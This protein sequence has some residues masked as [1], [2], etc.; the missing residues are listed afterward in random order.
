MAIFIV[1]ENSA[2]FYSPNLD[3]KI[4]LQRCG[5][6]KM[7]LLGVAFALLLVVVCLSSLF[8]L[9]LRKFENFLVLKNTLFSLF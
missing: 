3:E 1:K 6:G 9:S 4:H 8:F 2:L 5:G 7:R